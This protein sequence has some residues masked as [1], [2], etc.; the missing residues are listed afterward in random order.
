MTGSRS[1]S[2][3]RFSSERA[4]AAR[5]KKRFGQHFLSDRNILS[6]IVD[7]ADLPPGST[8]IEVGPGLGALT[9]LLAER[10]GQVIAVEVDRDLV[11]ALRTKFV[12]DTG[13]VT[14]IERDV[15]DVSPGEMLRA[16]DGGVPYAVVANLPY[17]IA[18]PVLRMFL[19]SDPAPERMVVMVQ[20]EVAQSICAPPPKMTLLGVATQVYGDAEHGDDGAARRVQSAAEGALGRRSGSTW[21]RS[22]R[23]MCR[24]TRS[25][26]IVRAGFGNPRKMLRN[27]LSFGLHVK[28]E[29]VDELMARGRRRGDA[30]AADAVAG[31]LG[32]HHAGV[33]CEVGL[34]RTLRAASHRRRST[35]RWKCCALR[36]DGYHEMRSV[37]QTIALHDVVTV[38]EADEHRRLRSW[39]TMAL[40]GEPP[41]SNLAVRAA[42][43]LRDRAGTATGRAHPAREARAAR[44]GPGWR[45]QRRARRCFGRSTSSGMRASR[46]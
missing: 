14:S 12:D 10:A 37:L 5:A 41:E 3:S 44:G 34:M 36:P 42:V 46:G 8:V 16:G 27:S 7:A 45:Q 17:N 6:R 20:Q 2:K 35:G 19:E 11:A 15:L 21:R 30:A 24:W 4:R 39:A 23:S 22:R 32:E 31:R 38:H 13:N 28:Q 9:E 29:V 40:A 26:E 43:A 1:G 25:F 18:A 33:A